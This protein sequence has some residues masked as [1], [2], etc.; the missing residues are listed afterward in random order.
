MRELVLAAKGFIIQRFL[1]QLV[2][3]FCGFIF[4]G[5][6]FFYNVIALC[7]IGVTFFARNLSGKMIGM[8]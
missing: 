2:D 5:F 7:I 4:W 6:F 1:S 3:L 8:H